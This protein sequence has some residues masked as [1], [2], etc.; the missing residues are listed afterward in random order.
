LGIQVPFK[1]FDQDIDVSQY[2]KKSS[3]NKV[4]NDITSQGSKLYDSQYSSTKKMNLRSG[5][6][7]KEYSSSPEI[8]D[9]VVE[10]VPK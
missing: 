9:T 2:S 1:E 8:D 4:G 3:S 7:V 5:S 6:E 10:N